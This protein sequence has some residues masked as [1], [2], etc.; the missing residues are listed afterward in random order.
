MQGSPTVSLKKRIINKE[1]VFA[2][3]IYHIKSNQIGTNQ[4]A[5]N[6]AFA[7]HV[8]SSWQTIKTHVVRRWFLE[9]TD[10]FPDFQSLFLRHQNL[11]Q[12][13]SKLDRSTST[14]RG[15]DATIDHNFFV[16][17]TIR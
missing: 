6:T 15:N 17:D 3:R 7:I 2:N 9:K 4:P 12:F 14:L 5:P 11:H 13:Q 8:S 16:F 1:L 10:G